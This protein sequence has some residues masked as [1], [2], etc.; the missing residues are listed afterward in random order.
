MA[1]KDELTLVVETDGTVRYV[2]DDRLAPVFAGE[3]QVTRRAS[4]VEPFRGGWIADMRPSGG[5]ILGDD[6][7][8]FTPQSVLPLDCIGEVEANIMR[9]QLR[10]FSTRQAAL[11]AERAWLR[12]E[13]G[14]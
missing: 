5:P 11:D 10:A 7:T 4:H 2:Y 13:E 9:Y 3:E 8:R 14:L 12:K 1:E 6:G